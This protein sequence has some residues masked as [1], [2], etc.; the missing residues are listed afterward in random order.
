LRKGFQ[1]FGLTL[2]GR[3]GGLFFGMLT[4]I[5]LAWNLG[6]DGRGSL[7]VCL[8]FAAILGMVFSVGSDIGVL[9]FVSSG[10]FSVSEGV[11]YVSIFA[12]IS[13]ILAMAAGSALMCAPLTFFAK[14]THG[15][16]LLS[17]LLVPATLFSEVFYRLLTAVHMFKAFALASVLKSS[18]QTVL[19]IGFVWWAG[20]GVNG[21]LLAS[22]VTAGGILGICLIFLLH[23]FPMVRFRPSIA[24]LK[25]MFWYGTRYYAGKISNMTNTQIGT[26]L[27]AFFA[28]P[29]EIG[30]FAV[31]SRMT[32]LVE[33]LPESITTVLFPRMASAPDGRKRLVVQT[34]QIVTIICGS[35]FLALSLLATP[36]V[37]I[38]FSP[39]FLPA[40]PLIRIL[41]IGGAV[42]CSGKI[43]LSYLIATKHPGVGSIA[44][45]IGVI[46]NVALLVVL[47]PWIGVSG[48][49]WAM[50]L[51]YVVSSIVLFWAFRRFSGVR[52]ADFFSFGGSD[53]KCLLTPIHH[54]FRKDVADG[55][56]K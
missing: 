8:V 4:Q 36:I 38:L 48:A 47:L 31:A 27:L 5:I 53:W 28:A 45:T 29:S 19:T 54:T 21:A 12:A 30:W 51:N 2:G 37:R 13:S 9:Y 6:P 15:A 52:F 26:V 39:E 33:I 44:V 24:D 18:L 22:I 14:A 32:N 40:V 7:A 34:S 41:S 11:F 1:D 49:A 42:F 25:A 23:N 17:L 43:F 35:I 46:V 16:F 55:D 50:A 10:N 56:R 3:V 20:W